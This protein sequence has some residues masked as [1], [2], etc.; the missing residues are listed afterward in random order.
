VGFALLAGA[1]AGC[2]SSVETTPGTGASGG[3]GG[4]A[5]ACVPAIEGW[6]KAGSL[7]TA[8][9]DHQTFVVETPAGAFLYVAGGA[10]TA[11]WTSSLLDV[12]RAEIHDDGTLGPFSVVA[13]LP[14]ITQEG[15]VAQ[16]GRTVFLVGGHDALSLGTTYVGQVGDDGGIAFTAGPPLGL[17]RHRHASFAHDG[18]VY[19]VGGV[20]QHYAENMMNTVV[21]P[22]DTIERAAFD[23]AAIGPFATVSSLPA[24]L[25]DHAIAVAG[26]AVYVLG[27][28]P[29]DS[30]QPTSD[31]LR[32]PFLAGGELGAFTWASAFVAGRERM[33]AFALSGSVFALG[34]RYA[35]EQV[36]RAPMHGDGTLG[37][38]AQLEDLPEAREVRQAP[39]YKG[40][41]FVAGGARPD[42]LA[43][44]S[45]VVVAKIVSKAP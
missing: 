30:A 7:L 15:S 14:G 43:P 20:H 27:G 35:G 32:A 24:P 18:F 6:T 38:F 44:L 34:G 12:E 3:G 9:R 5:S 28:H 16:I 45:D 17:T 23:G 26:D 19:A 29:A 4:C 37:A 41:V 21:D 25:S 39:V 11:A 8:R 31:V 42:D 36:L 10:G 1:L 2:S 22:T 33:A 13:T 40:F